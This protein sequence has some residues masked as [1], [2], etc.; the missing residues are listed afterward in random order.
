MTPREANYNSHASL[1]RPAV[2]FCLTYV[3]P[4]GKSPQLKSSYLRHS[5]EKLSCSDTGTD[6]ICSSSR[7]SRNDYVAERESTVAGATRFRSEQHGCDQCSCG[8]GCQNPE[9]HVCQLR[10]RGGVSCALC[11]A[12][13][14]QA[15]PELTGKICGDRR[16]F[17][18]LNKNSEVTRTN[19]SDPSLASTASGST[20]AISRSWP[21]RTR[22]KRTWRFSRASMHAPHAA[23][24]PTT[25]SRR[26]KFSASCSPRSCGAFISD[27]SFL[28]LW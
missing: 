24:S 8:E 9:L 4:R 1:A 22:Q 18:K 12:V 15:R 19:L 28:P 10:L 26:P 27:R 11:T 6:A 13:R 7:A 17:R 3:D 21:S 14:S 5:A 25:T 16:E 20:F 23:G 2:G